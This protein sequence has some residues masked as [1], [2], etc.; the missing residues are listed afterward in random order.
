MAFAMPL[1]LRCKKIFDFFKKGLYKAGR[2]WYHTN[3]NNNR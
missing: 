3:A 2:I 1:F